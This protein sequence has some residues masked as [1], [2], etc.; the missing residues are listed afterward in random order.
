[1]NWLG[2]IIKGGGIILKP[3]SLKPGDTIAITG[4]AGPSSEENIRLARE[5]LEGLGFR[6]KLASSCFSSYGYLAGR[7]DLRAGDLNRMFADKGVDGIICLRGGYGSSRILDKV[8]FH[9]IRANP[10][11]FVGYSDITAL[12]IAINQISN[13]LTFHGP[14]AAPDL[15]PG[16]DSF[17]KKE[18]LRALME[19][20]AMGDIL[21]PQDEEIGVMVRGRARGPI[22][23]GNLSLISSTMG[24][25]YE[26]DTRGKI[27]FLEEVGEE[28]YRIDRMLTQL[29][30]GGKFDGAEG[31]ILGDWKACQSKLYSNSLSLMEL[32]E[33]IIKPYGK[34]TIYNLKAGHCRP[35]LTLP[36]G[37]RALLDG[38]RGKLIIE[39][40]A[41][42]Q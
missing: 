8:D 38:D 35:K 18:F 41:T 30:L 32:F 11:V 42:R 9:L 10:K 25:P 3:R 20:Q 17:S 23:G 22:I 12:H 40:G 36:L 33:N 4:P 21:N 6:V 34:P 29:A 13:L 27:L 15:A 24:T 39:E 28:P 14:M 31:I 26:I 5:Q 1:M 16:L 37:A 19:P 7:D 2:P